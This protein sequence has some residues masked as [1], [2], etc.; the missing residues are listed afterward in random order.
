M[1]IVERYSTGTG[2]I[3]LWQLTESTDELFRITS[4]TASETQFY[5]TLQNDRR[6]REW[7]AWHAMLR[8]EVGQGVPTAYDGVGKPILENHD[9]FISVS[10]CDGYVALYISE[11]QCGI[12]IEVTDRNYQRTA[13][14]FMSPEENKVLFAAA[15][16]KYPLAWCTKEA[17]YK[18]LGRE[19]VDFLEDMTV[20]DFTLDRI[21]VRLSDK[22]L[23]NLSY[24]FH[25]TITVV[26]TI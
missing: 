12:D 6:K 2:N 22:K 24:R 3:A 25:E 26:Y 18:Y 10:H 1:P 7:L 11:K 19:G 15:E 16:K 23:V 21:S 4:L 5:K 8:M 20:C 9:G 14:R 13:S 17:V